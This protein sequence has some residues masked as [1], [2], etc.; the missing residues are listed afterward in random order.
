LQPL[1]LLCNIYAFI[2][3]NASF[4]STNP[5]AAV[6]RAAL[7]FYASAAVMIAIE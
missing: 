7:L 1:S 2:I 4:G 5:F 6:C 3:Q